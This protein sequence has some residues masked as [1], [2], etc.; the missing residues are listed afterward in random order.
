MRIVLAS[1]VVV[2]TM[3]ACSGRNAD[4]PANDGAA[5]K[6][7]MA[8]LIRQ[9][10][11]I[12]ATEHSDQIDLPNE[13]AEK[14]GIHEQLIY[15]ERELSAQ[16]RTFFLATIESLDPK[17][18]DAFAACVPAVRHSFRFYSGGRL[19]DTVDICFECGQVLWGG[20]RAVPPWSLYSG[21]A[22]VVEHVGFSPERD[23]PAVARQHLKGSRPRG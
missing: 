17:T 21:L 5:Y 7:A 18:Q 19:V 11:R 15:G 10:D 23:W 2:V 3:I 1:I 14:F 9:S 4:E 20:T 8:N 12:V 22:K 13:D 6:R 16:Q